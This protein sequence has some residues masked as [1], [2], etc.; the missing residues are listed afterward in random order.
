MI[1]IFADIDKRDILI[2]F[3]YLSTSEIYPD[4]KRMTFGWTVLLGGV[5]YGWT[6]HLRRWIYG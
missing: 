6:G 3:Y 1:K 2:I 5:I 4:K